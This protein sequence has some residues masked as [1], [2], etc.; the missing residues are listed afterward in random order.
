MYV[1]YTSKLE[2]HFLQI[3]RLYNIRLSRILEQL[4]GF[5]AAWVFRA[6]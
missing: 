5:Y 6:T 3:V 1:N 2:K 4:N